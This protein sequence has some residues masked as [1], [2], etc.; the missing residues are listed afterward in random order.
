MKTMIKKILS[1]G[2][3]LDGNILIPKEPKGKGE[4]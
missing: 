1:E 3:D 2:R 4:N